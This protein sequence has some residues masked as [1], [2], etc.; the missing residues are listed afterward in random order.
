METNFHGGPQQV[1]YKAGWF[2]KIDV[3]KPQSP[4]K[5]LSSDNDGTGEERNNSSAAG[6]TGSGKARNTPAARNTAGGGNKNGGGV[7]AD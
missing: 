3:P 6:S 4:E 1:R 7:L 2:E 5:V